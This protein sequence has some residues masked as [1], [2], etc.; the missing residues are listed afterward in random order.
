MD[1]ISLSHLVEGHEY[2]LGICNSLKAEGLWTRSS[3]KIH[4]L[5][6]QREFPGY[7]ID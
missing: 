5:N 4:S 3:I 6:Q 2:D 7:S 1:H